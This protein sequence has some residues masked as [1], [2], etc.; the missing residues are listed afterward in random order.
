MER[1]EKW[2]VLYPRKILTKLVAEQDG[3]TVV[4]GR[5]PLTISGGLRVEQG[6]SS[7]FSYV[8]VSFGGRR[9]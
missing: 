1:E 5:D 4:N 6:G 2:V 7:G 9:E 3:Q 8:K